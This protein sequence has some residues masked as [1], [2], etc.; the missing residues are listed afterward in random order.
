MYLLLMFHSLVLHWLVSFLKVPCRHYN[1]NLKRRRRV[2]NYVREETVPRLESYH[3]NL[4]E[5]LLAAG[6]TGRVHPRGRILRHVSGLG[7]IVQANIT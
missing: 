5:M 4:P 6:F 3:E 7:H 2:V 1:S